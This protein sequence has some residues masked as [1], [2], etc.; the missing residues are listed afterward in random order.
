LLL[1][2]HPNPPKIVLDKGSIRILEE[3]NINTLIAQKD[4]LKYLGQLQHPS[5]L[6][7]V[8]RLK[9]EIVIE[10]SPKYYSKWNHCKQ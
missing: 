5:F 8:E 2:Q 3:V 4:A 10:V 7:F 1:C 6:E 9:K